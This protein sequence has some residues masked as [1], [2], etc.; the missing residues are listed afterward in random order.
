MKREAGRKEDRMERREETRAGV[1][2][3]KGRKGKKKTGRKREQ[4][5][6]DGAIQ[7]G[8]KEGSEKTRKK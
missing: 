7:K 6:M 3:Y 5:R 4:G 1:R 2:I 8:R